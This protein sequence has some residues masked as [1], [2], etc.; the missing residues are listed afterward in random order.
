MLG[1]HSYN[2]I[3]MQVEENSII[4]HKPATSDNSSSSPA[5]EALLNKN[6]LYEPVFLGD[7]GF[8]KYLNSMQKHRFLDTLLLPFPVDI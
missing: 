8:Y 7:Q 2:F 3:I 5:V 4:M 6:G 1:S